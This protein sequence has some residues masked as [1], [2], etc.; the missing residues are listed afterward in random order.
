VRDRVE[1]SISTARALAQ[2]L[3]PVHLDRD[4]FAG[5]LEQLCVNS[6]SLYGIPVK[7]KGQ[8]SDRL[9]EPAAAVD[10]YRIAQEAIRNAASHSGATEIRLILTTDDRQLALTVEDDGQGIIAGADANGGMGLKIMRYRASIIGAS[11]EI[12]AS[13]QGGTAVSC[14]LRRRA[15]HEMTGVGNG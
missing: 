13:E 14:V 11:L 9:H 10:L 6:E 4:G 7:F 3:S 2:G 8:R 15:E 5:A 1:Q 12:G